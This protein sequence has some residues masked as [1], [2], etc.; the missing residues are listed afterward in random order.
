MRM[1]AI[2]S[3]AV[4]LVVALAFP[5]AACPLAGTAPSGGGQRPLV[6]V[7]DKDYRPLSYLDGDAPRGLDVEMGEAVAAALGRPARV[8]LLGWE[9][10]QEKVRAGEADLVLDMS[11]TEARKALFDFSAPVFEHEFAFFVRAGDVQVSGTADLAG[12]RVGVTQGGYPRAV[13]AKNPGVQLVLVERYR[14]GLLQLAAGAIDAFAGDLWVGADAIQANHLTGI[15][16]AGPPFAR[17]PYAM[18]VRKGDAA[19]LAD[20]DRALS[21]LER[22]GTLA[23]IRSRWR[24]QEIVFASRQKVRDI[25][26][27]TVA[28]GLF[29]VLGGLGLWVRSLKRHISVQ[30]RTQGALRESE[31]RL[32]TAFAMFPDAVVMSRPDSTVTLVNEGFTRLTGWSAEEAQGR[33]K[34]SLGL[35]Q[36]PAQLACLYETVLSGKAIRNAEARFLARDG[37]K[38]DATGQNELGAGIIVQVQDGKYVTVWPFDL[39]SKDVVWPMPPWSKR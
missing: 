26:L 13:L 9:H 20:V 5:R 35:W 23:G 6:M 3:A 12:K 39:A 1:L 7:A 29:L 32:R 11:V 16:L 19:T 28:G 15:A 37:I 38:F 31:E 27:A 17:Q 8:E 14:D 10:A 18:A 2:S 30:R 25:V 34:L 36:D 4:A 21:Q 33:T 22:D 24:P